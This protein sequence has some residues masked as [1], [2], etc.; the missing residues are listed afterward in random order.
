LLAIS[1]YLLLKRRKSGAEETL[2]DGPNSL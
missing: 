2:S 1:V